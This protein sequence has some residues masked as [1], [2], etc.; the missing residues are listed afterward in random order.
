MKGRFALSKRLPGWMLAGAVL[1]LTGC[2]HHPQ[3]AYAPPPPAISP[4]YARS[5]V[6]G[7]LRIDGSVQHAHPEC[8]NG[9]TWALELRRGHTHERLASGTSKGAT[10]I[11]MGHF[12]NIRVLPGDVLSVVIG[13][14]EG[15]HACDL[16]AVDLALHDGT[17]EWNLARD[18]SPDILAGNP[19]ADSH[20]NKNV[21]H[22]FG[23][24]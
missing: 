22:F 12:E 8:G 19:H 7:T 5:P 6:T 20:G 24:P 1:A 9:I 11:N 23:E 16:T 14:R 13:P 10:L 21:C 2:H 4:G 15:N 3:T 17:R 18:I